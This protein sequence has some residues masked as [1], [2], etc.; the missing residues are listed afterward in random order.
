MI[1]QEQSLSTVIN[2]LKK[3]A[4]TCKLSGTIRE[5]L[6]TLSL[7]MKTNQ[8]TIV[9]VG[10]FKHGK[11]TFIN[12]LLGQ[13]LL[14]TDILPTTAVIHRIF[15][16]DKDELIVHDQKGETKKFDLDKD[17][18]QHFTAEHAQS[19]DQ[20]K[21]I[22]L[23]LSK[24]PFDQNIVI[25][26]TPG[27]NDLNQQRA[28]VAYDFIPRSDAVIF[29][30]DS[31]AF[32]K[33]TEEEFIKEKLLSQDLNKIVFIANFIDR[34]DE[35]ETDLDELA[36][37]FK[38]R[39]THSLG[40]PR[41]SLYLLSS[42]SALQGRIE[43]NDELISFS[44]ILPIEKRITELTE[45]GTRAQEKQSAYVY[46]AI[47]I[48][49]QINNEIRTCLVT[50]KQSTKELTAVLENLNSWEQK[51][52]E[53]LQSVHD[54][55]QLR[56][57]EIH[58][59][60]E[61]S[62]SNLKERLLDEGIQAINNFDSPD[63]SQLTEK[64]L[65]QLSERF[66]KGWLEEYSPYILELLNKL[67]QSIEKGLNE[68]FNSTIELGAV[69]GRKLSS[70]EK[71][72]VNV[73]SGMDTTITSGLIVGGIATG[74]AIL[75]MSLFVPLLAMGG[76]PIIRDIMK[77]NKL[78]KLKPEIKKEWERIIPESINGFYE[79]I[80]DQVDQLIQ[81]TVTNTQEIFDQKA[82]VRRQIIEN[83]QQE[84]AREAEELA[85]QEQVLLAAQGDL[86][87]LDAQLQ[88]LIFKSEPK[89]MKNNEF[90]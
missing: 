66:I 8:Y 53:T 76:I 30:L 88:M 23:S 70:S 27:V 28:E 42:L 65:P 17:V 60:I 19:T 80:C 38:R 71:V 58:H 14:P 29:V 72:N 54:Y 46:R 84:N 73:D 49:R 26:D 11:S 15:K 20:V 64:I 45:S 34:L 9:V 78:G 86:E 62:I 77:K 74:L 16:G 1:T 22:D 82:T 33:R 89:G 43:Q 6:A 2:E 31:G 51:K 50:G 3:Q 36:E 39:I 35:E 47:H 41:P 67:K 44:G 40:L 87:K 32:L 18:M 79:S 24:V 81:N 7:D 83:T 25:V 61:K 37:D 56:E 68:Y 10:E 55:V 75:S 52:D 59:L 21:Y 85:K 13:D 90:I 48:L 5:K 69:G 12:S 63:V 4:I 57:T